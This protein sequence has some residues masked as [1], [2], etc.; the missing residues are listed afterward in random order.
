[1]IGLLIDWWSIQENNES[2]G[3]ISMLKNLVYKNALIFLEKKYSAKWYYFKKLCNFFLI[4]NI[5]VL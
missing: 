2:I 1:M 4:E 5:S 3:I